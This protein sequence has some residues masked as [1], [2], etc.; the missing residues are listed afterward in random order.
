MEFS[1]AKRIHLA[2]DPLASRV[3]RRDGDGVFKRQR[4]WNY[5]RNARGGEAQKPQPSGINRQL[6]IPEGSSVESRE[7]RRDER[8][9]G[10]ERRVSGPW[11][12]RRVLEIYIVKWIVREFSG[13]WDGQQSERRREV[14]TGKRGS[15]LQIYGGPLRGVWVSRS[16]SLN[17]FESIMVNL[18]RTV[19]VRLWWIVLETSW[20][21]ERNKCSCH[22]RF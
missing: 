16:W 6:E 20:M 18:R 14:D 12:T 7:E 2:P 8:G 22:L 11:Y 1:Y 9:E 15:R 3:D 4:Y 17:G 10:K 13:W 5:A 19:T 21:P